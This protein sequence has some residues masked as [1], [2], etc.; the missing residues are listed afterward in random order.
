MHSPGPVTIDTDGDVYE[1]SDQRA[2]VPGLEPERIR[3]GIEEA[4]AGRRYSLKDIIAARAR[5]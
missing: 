2:I 4:V 1:H 5:T 3:R